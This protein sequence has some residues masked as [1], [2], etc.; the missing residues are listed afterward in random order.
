MKKLGLS[1]L[2]LIISCT[3]FAYA[4]QT[5]TFATEAT[6]PPFVSMTAND[7]MVGFGPDLVRALC[8]IMQTNCQLVNAPWE[9]LIPS[10]KMGKYDALFG[11]MGITPAR[12]K[13]ID[14]SLPYYQNAM[15]FVANKSTNFSLKQQWLKGKTI[16]VQGGTTFQNYLQT[17]FGKLITIK[18]YASN[19]AALMDLKAGR[20]NAV[21]L[22]KPVA[23]TWLQKPDNQ[24]YTTI[25]NI[26]SVKF[27]GPGNAIAIN[28]GNTALQQKINTAIKTMQANG[29]L[30][31]LQTKWFGK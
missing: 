19:M 31:K 15:S 26:T 8:K 3:Q 17:K 18:T 11:G 4:K 24:T 23:I 6:Y 2:L 1:L 5:L 22:D 28:Q 20:V 14:F 25:G 27:F 16:G 7:K 10:L 21:F 12:Q 13:V 29:Q 30:K 9:S